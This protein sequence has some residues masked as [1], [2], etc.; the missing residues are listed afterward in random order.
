LKRA[1]F[2]SPIKIVSRPDFVGQYVGHTCDK[3]QKL[4]TTT[5]E[6]GKVLFIDEAYSLVLDEKDSF[7]HECLNEINRFMSENPQLVMIFAGYKD[8]M[9]ASIF[10]SQPG[11]ARR[12]SWNFEILNYTGE[13][14]SDIFKKQLAK[15]N[16]IFD[17]KLEDL[18]NFFQDKIKNFSSFGGDTLRLGFYCKL[19]YSELKFDY[20]TRDKLK[21]KTITFDILKTAYTDMYCLNKPEKDEREEV[22]R[23]LYN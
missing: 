5:L 20:N 6:E 3:T 21:D 13:M 18:N 23:S 4:L 2:E 7:G 14:L 22:W 12:I 17:D 8:K 15:D 11:L 9:E 19:K 16:W 1:K 10:K